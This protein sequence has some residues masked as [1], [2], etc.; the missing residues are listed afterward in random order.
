MVISLL[1]AE[2]V[3]LVHG[4]AVEYQVSVVEPEE[5]LLVVLVEHGMM[6][7]IQVLADLAEVKQAVM[8]LVKVAQ[9]AAH[10]MAL[11]AEAAEASTVVEAEALVLDGHVAAAV[12]LA[13]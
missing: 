4:M 2:A 5:A 8:H 10:I 11:V 13:G 6:K 9:V 7:V 12:A 3:L 1:E